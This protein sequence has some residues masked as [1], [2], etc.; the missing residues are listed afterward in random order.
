MIIPLFRNTDCYRS[1]KTNDLDIRKI[2]ENLNPFF[3]NLKKWLQFSGLKFSRR[4]KHYYNGY[5]HYQHYNV[6]TVKSHSSWVK[7][8]SIRT[9]NTENCY[10]FYMYS[11]WSIFM[12]ANLV[13]SAML[14]QSNLQLQTPLI[15][16][17]LSSVTNFPK[18]QKFS[19]QITLLSNL[20]LQTPLISSQLSSVTSL[21]KYQKLI[22]F[23]LIL[24]FATPQIK[25]KTIQEKIERMD[26]TM[27]RRPKGN[28]EAYIN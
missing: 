9:R 26:L 15:N 5:Y 17:Q 8:L 22:W 25:M 2:L 19:S 27:A 18:Y 11:S 16:S 13:I 12:A 1:K 20:Q 4:F 28:Y 21:P 24:I 6:L 23:D 3:L 7:L 10:F 14:L